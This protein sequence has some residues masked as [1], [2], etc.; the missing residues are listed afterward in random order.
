MR[1]HI[2]LSTFSQAVQHWS[3]VYRCSGCSAVVHL[4][5]AT[6]SQWYI[7]AVLQWTEPHSSGTS[8]QCSDRATFSSTSSQCSVP[9][10]FLFLFQTSFL[11]LF[12][13]RLLFFFFLF[14]LGIVIL[15]IVIYGSWVA[16]LFSSFS[17]V[18]GSW[19]TALSP[20]LQQ[21]AALPSTRTNQMSLSG[22]PVSSIGLRDRDA[23]CRGMLLVGN[24]TPSS[25]VAVHCPQW[26]SHGCSRESWM[27]YLGPSR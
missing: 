2:I 3:I 10:S 1:P 14:F 11:F 9:P 5:S 16:T 8:S 13:V 6:S 20:V 27:K 23:E 17:S 7:F 15:G 26:R 25:A 24:K 21:V 12:F 4:R 22:S 19:V 18:L